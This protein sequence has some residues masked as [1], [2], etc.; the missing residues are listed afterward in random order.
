MNRQ[1]CKLILLL[2]LLATACTEDIKEENTE[3]FSQEITPVS[4]TFEDESFEDSRYLELLL[5]LRICDPSLPDQSPLIDGVAPCSPKYFAFYPYNHNRDIS[6][7]FILQIRKG[8]NQFNARR[9]LIFTRENSGLVKMNGA[10]GYLAERRS[11]PN[12]IDDLVVGIVD[13]VAGEYYRYDVL[14]RYE[15]GKYHFV[16]ALGD[17]EGS[18]ENDPDLKAAATREIGL[19]IEQKK[20]LF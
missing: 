13:N 16:E 18:F 19:R 17:I 11:S 2:S 4:T 9:M 1:S 20:L 10:V 12:G 5:S 7:A 3:V 6:D 15:N 14:L 8:V